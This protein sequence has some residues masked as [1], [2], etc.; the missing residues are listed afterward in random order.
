MVIISDLLQSRLRWSIRRA[1]GNNSGRKECPPAASVNIEGVHALCP[2]KSISC[3]S[4]LPGKTS[5]VFT[6]M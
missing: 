4:Y 6:K 3:S 2:R 5:H 1:E